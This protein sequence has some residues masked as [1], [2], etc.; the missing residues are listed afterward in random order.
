ML[1]LV[2]GR[3]MNILRRIWAGWKRLGGLIGDVVGRLVLTLLYF[4]IVLPFGLIARLTSDPL[5]VRHGRPASWLEREP[6]EGTLD[7]AERLS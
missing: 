5:A 1:R 6:V 7:E 3:M 4:T 2:H